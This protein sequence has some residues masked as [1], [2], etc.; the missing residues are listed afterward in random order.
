VSTPVGD[1]QLV[2]TG[3]GGVYYPSTGDNRNWVHLENEFS[4]APVPVQR[5][6]W[7]QLR[8]RYAPDRSAKPGAS[9]R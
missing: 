2:F 6:G 9:A 3:N 4:G 5:E 7:G 8:S 1:S